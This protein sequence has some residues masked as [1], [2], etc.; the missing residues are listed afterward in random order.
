MSTVPKRWLSPQEYVA[1][2]RLADFRSE[3]FRG[4]TFAMAGGSPRHSRIKINVGRDLS[5][6]LE[7]KPCDVFDSDLR[8][9]ISAT[10]LYT[11]PDFS[12]ICGELRY[13]DV[14]PDTVINPTL[15]IEVLSPSTETYD[16]GTKFEHY[17]QIATL[18]EYVLISQDSP[19]IERRS[20]QSDG[21]WPPTI[22]TGLDQMLELPSIGVTPFLARIY[23][24]VEFVPAP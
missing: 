5:I 20:R 14:F 7:D 3:Y 15:L 11:Y 10:G 17:Q 9:L 4:E 18:Q 23:L 13:D 12:V 8:I 24:K 22:V 21:T 16:R 1:Q 2:E 6:A 19:T